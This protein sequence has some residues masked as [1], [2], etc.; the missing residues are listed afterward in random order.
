M[1]L[2]G[3]SEQPGHAVGG[4]KMMPDAV[5]LDP[6]NINAEPREPPQRRGAESPQADYDHVLPD[7]FHR[8]RPYYHSRAGLAPRPLAIPAHGYVV[9][10]RRVLPACHCTVISERRVQSHLFPLA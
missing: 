2:A 1:V 9:R 4:T 3:D 8:R 6:R 7:D 5:T 10:F